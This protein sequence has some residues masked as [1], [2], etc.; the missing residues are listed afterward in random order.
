[1]TTRKDLR[2]L[3]RITGEISGWAREIDRVLH[4]TDAAPPP[5][6]PTPAPA[7]KYPL[8][9]GYSRVTCKDCD[10][11]AILIHGHHSFAALCPSCRVIT[12]LET[13]DQEHDQEPHK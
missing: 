12:H 2:D 9:P 3:K 10:A 6:R 5:K 1:M 7:P 4:G 8:P 13:I 11:P